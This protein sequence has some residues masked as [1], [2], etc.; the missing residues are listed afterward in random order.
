MPV[1]TQAVAS[2]RYLEHHVAGIKPSSSRDKT[3]TWIVQGF[4]TQ[5]QAEFHDFKDTLS[6]LLD[7]HQ[8]T[9]DSLEP[10]DERLLHKRCGCYYGKYVSAL[11]RIIGELREIAL[12]IG[13]KEDEVSNMMIF[14]W[15]VTE[16]RIGPLVKDD[17]SIDR[18]DNEII[19]SQ[20]TNFRRRWQ[21]GAAGSSRCKH[22]RAPH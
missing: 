15:V 2:F 9:E 4:R 8:W 16:F 1:T 7:S 18:A 3:E 11:W 10:V 21:M 20:A 19:H 22:S 6:E 14:S 5:L 17:H 12:S 13:M